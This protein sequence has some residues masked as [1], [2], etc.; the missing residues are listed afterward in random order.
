MSLLWS[1]DKISCAFVTVF[2]HSLT[3]TQS[4][5]RT[6]DSRDF[7]RM[8]GISNNNVKNIICLHVGNFE[9]DNDDKW[10]LFNL[11]KRCD[12]LEEITFFECDTAIFPAGIFNA[13]S[14]RLRKV[15]FYMCRITN[16]SLKCI[17]NLANLKLLSFEKCTFLGEGFSLSAFSK[18]EHVCFKLNQFTSISATAFSR[19]DNLRSLIFQHNKIRNGVPDSL[20]Y[21]LRNLEKVDF[22]DC[23][24][25]KIPRDMFR[26]TKKLQKLFICCDKITRFDEIFFSHLPSLRDFDCWWCFDLE[27]FPAPALF[28]HCKKLEKFNH[29]FNVQSIEDIMRSQ[30]SNTEMA[31]FIRRCDLNYNKTIYAH[32][33]YN[34]DRSP[35]IRDTS[36]E[37][38]E[39]ILG[40][41]FSEKTYE[42]IVEQ[43]TMMF[44]DDDEKTN[45][46]DDDSYFSL[47]HHFSEKGL[48]TLLATNDARLIRILSAIVCLVEQNDFASCI[49]ECKKSNHDVDTSSLLI[50]IRQEIYKL[51]NQELEE[52]DFLESCRLGQQMRLVN[53]LSG[54]TDFVNI[55]V[56]DEDQIHFISV[57][58][59]LDHPTSIEGQQKQFTE[60]MK[61]YGYSDQ[62]VQK[63]LIG[64]DDEEQN[65]EQ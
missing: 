45:I 19:L 21:D 49:A 1:S 52:D 22:R 60:D 16:C 36:D 44:R 40:A 42:K 11:I 53:C 56:A 35:S 15:K 43:L 20:F 25:R 50:S 18:L 2:V 38:C 59:R 64:F 54:F 55:R 51:L 37:A 17:E 28:T 14:H 8:S 62:V 10:Q 4:D 7:N 5:I 27:D 9:R 57:K 48:Q 41:Y 34:M 29:S 30:W 12:N 23:G 31:K 26:G 47:Q 33:F 65:N 58:A 24:F 46:D 32:P 39:K 63:W 6:Y 61:A 13:R 3:E